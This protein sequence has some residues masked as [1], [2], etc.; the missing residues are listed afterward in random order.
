M[1][2]IHDY[3]TRRG[4]REKALQHWSSRWLRHRKKVCAA[5]PGVGHVASM[6]RHRKFV[7]HDG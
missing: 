6:G 3:K 4:G 1:D 7:D 2:F 5:S